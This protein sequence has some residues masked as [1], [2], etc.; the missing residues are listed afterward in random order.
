VYIPLLLNDVAEQTRRLS[1]ELA[2]A[3]ALSYGE[4]LTMLPELFQVD[5]VEKQVRRVM[6]P[7]T[8]SACSSFM[9][10]NLKQ[11]YWCHGIRDGTEVA[12]RP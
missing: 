2:T 10:D 7:Q 11:T 3:D 8:L 4:F 9:G 5:E 12:A 6:P 1:A